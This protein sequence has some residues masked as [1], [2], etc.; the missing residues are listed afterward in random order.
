MK[1]KDKG[2]QY[3]LRW[4]KSKKV[5]KCCVPSCKSVD[6]KA[7]RLFTCDSI[8]IASIELP[9]DICLCTKH[10]QQVYR[11]LNEKSDACTTC[12]VLRHNCNS[13]FFSCPNPKRIEPFLREVVSVNVSVD[14]SGQECCLCYKFFKRMLASDV[15]MLSSEDIVS[16]LQAK[17]KN[18][19]RIV[20]EFEYITLELFDI[21][22][23]C[24]YK[25]AL[26]ACEL[27]ASDCPF[28]FP[29]MYRLCSKLVI[30]I[31]ND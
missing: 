10:Y 23:W 24:L 2:D 19:E 27:V 17:K 5:S 28:L 31:L 18:L 6:I 29:N 3:R 21:V 20:D 13:N 4:L 8:G 14:N 11:M 26:H 9:G 12:G 7:E 15:C 30:T 22:Q 16:E 1:C 25:T